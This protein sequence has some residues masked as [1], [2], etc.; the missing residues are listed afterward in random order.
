MGSTDSDFPGKKRKGQEKPRLP[1]KAL[2]PFHAQHESNQ[3]GNALKAPTYR[4]NKLQLSVCYRCNACRTVLRIM[5]G[6]LLSLS[7][8]ERAQ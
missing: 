4:T 3:T 2:A 7:G 5:L 6:S 1:R 8:W